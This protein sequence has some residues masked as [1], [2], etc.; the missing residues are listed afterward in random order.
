MHSSKR[1]GLRKDGHIVYNRFQGHMAT[2]LR[3]G[4]LTLYRDTEEQD[5]IFLASTVGS[6]DGHHDDDLLA[7]I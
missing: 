5:L 6:T 3:K 2:L 7:Y 1:C 4:I